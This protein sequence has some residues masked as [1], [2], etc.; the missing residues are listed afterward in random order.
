M[1][2]GYATG[3]WNAQSEYSPSEC[4]EWLKGT[5]LK[6]TWYKCLWNNHVMPKHQFTGWLVAHG[7]LRTRD[8]LIGYGLDIDDRCLLCEQE[9]ECIEYI[10]CDC[11]YSRRVIQAISQKM[12]ITFPVND[13]VVWC[14]QR[15]GTKLQKG[16]QAALMWGVIYHVWQ[17]RNKSN[18][19]GVLLRPERL[20]EQ[21][22]EEV[23]ARVRG[24]DYKVLTKTD[25]D[26]LRQKNLYVLD[27]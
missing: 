3:K 18:M 8:K 10:L 12:Q 11:I 24:R 15:T 16:I 22:I 25:I 20:A 23:K 1:L 5:N 9:T 19:E 13:M 7:A 2:P 26:W 6:V 4:Y 21:V 14:T 27:D 17:Q